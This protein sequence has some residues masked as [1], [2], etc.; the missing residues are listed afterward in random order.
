MGDVVSEPVLVTGAAGFVGSH[1]VRKLAARGQ[2]VRALV[3]R[4]S[5]LRA[6]EGLPVEQVTGDLRDPSSLR[7]AVSGCRQVYHVAA[8]YR[9]WARHPQELYASN[10]TGTVNLLTAARDAGAERIVYTSTVGALGYLARPPGGHPATEDTPVSLEM[11]IGHYKRSKFLAEQEVHRLVREG[12]PVIIVNP[13]TPVGSWDHKPTSTGQMIVDFLNGGMSGYVDT[14]LNLIDV[15]DVAEGHLLAMERGRV[16]ERYILGY[17]NLTLADILRILAKVS[18][19]PAPHRKVPWA[20]AYMAGCVSTGLAWLT[21][22]P[23]AIPLD[24]VRMARH[25]M[26]FDASKAVRELG[27]PQHPVEEALSKAVVWFREHGYLRGRRRS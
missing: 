4:G 18:G 10:V 16:G 17:R 3:R 22:R 13:S 20:V 26:F 8:D 19:R 25:Y 24:G 23:P 14:G 12:S 7:A 9:L 2:R 21:N 11:M 27:L 1:V 5:D 15:E 6:L